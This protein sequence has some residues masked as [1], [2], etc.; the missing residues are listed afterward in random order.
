MIFRRD[1]PNVHNLVIVILIVVGHQTL[2]FDQFLCINST[3]IIAPMASP[4]FNNS[5]LVRFNIIN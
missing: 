4:L 1:S 5:R 2:Y 3:S